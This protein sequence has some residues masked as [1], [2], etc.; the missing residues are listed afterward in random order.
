MADP[1]TF[2]WDILNGKTPRTAFDNF[3]TAFPQIYPEYLERKGNT[4]ASSLPMAPNQG[5]YGDMLR[6]HLDAKERIKG[7]TPDEISAAQAYPGFDP[8]AQQVDSTFGIMPKRPSGPRVDPLGGVAAGLGSIGS[9]VANT[10][11]PDVGL[12]AASGALKGAGYGAM[13]G[14]LGAGVGALIGGLTGAATSGI[15]RGRYDEMTGNTEKARIKAATVF[16]TDIGQYA[17]G[18]NIE[19]P[20]GELIP[21]QTEKGE[22]IVIEDGSIFKTKAT[23]THKQMDADEITDL[24][25]SGTH[26]AS[27]SKSESMTKK[28]ADK[29]IMG[30]DIVTYDE[31]GNSS[32]PK[33]NKLG[34]LFKKKQMTHA[35]ILEA[36][37]DKYPTN[38]DIKYDPFLR[39]ANKENLKSRL[40]YIQAVIQANL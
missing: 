9:V 40:P 39:K 18:G 36:V 8:A 31:A 38:D 22:V 30:Y 24:L 34:D 11:R 33:E 13:L 19:G 7:Y 15:N 23:K 26:V 35:E 21:V 32:K 6:G 17:G 2:L 3:K 28:D 5:Q 37:K 1:N 10:G 16:G 29:I 25:L 14:P 20:P 12:G 27:N 4:V